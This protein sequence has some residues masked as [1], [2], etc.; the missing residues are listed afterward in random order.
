M[1]RSYIVVRETSHP[2]F[3][4]V[5]PFNNLLPARGMKVSE[6]S[7]EAM[8]AR[9]MVTAKSFIHRPK[10][11]VDMKL[12]DT[13]TT[14]VVIVEMVTTRDTSLLP[15]TEASRAEYPFFSGLRAEC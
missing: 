14:S 10:P 3:S 12:R 1:I 4:R 11:V 9:E 6:M 15:L 8:S 5:F 13:K 2:A 7:R